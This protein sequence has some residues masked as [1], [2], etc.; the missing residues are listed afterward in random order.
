MEHEENYNPLRKD[1]YRRTALHRAVAGGRMEVLKYFIEEKSLVPASTGEYKGTLLHYAAQFKNLDIV[2][3]LVTKHQMDPLTQDDNGYTALHTACQGGDMNVVRY[4][5][6][7]IKKFSSLE[8]V[9]YDKTKDGKAPIHFAALY[10][11]LE[12]VQLF[13]NE[14]KW[15]YA[16]QIPQ[17]SGVGLHFTAQVK[18]VTWMWLPIL[19]KRK[20]VIQHIVQ[21]KTRRHHYT[22]QP[23]VDT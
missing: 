3:Y 11:H 17:V 14:L 12:V 5:I 6:N 1:K 21:V 10:G 19:S 7:E 8:D 2:D 15:H 13:I 4:I 18:V 9:I 16:T 23:N 22:W 20:S